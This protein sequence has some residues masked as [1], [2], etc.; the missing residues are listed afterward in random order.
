MELQQVI[1]RIEIEDLLCRYTHAIDTKNWDLLDEIFTPDAEIDYTEVGGI[2]AGLQEMKEW[3]AKSLS[4]FSLTQHLIGKSNIHLTGDKA[5]CSTI[6]HNPMVMP[7]NKEGKYDAEGK[8]T[9]TL[10]VGCWY[11]DTCVK[12]SDGW[13][14]S[15]KYEK[16]GF[17]HGSMPEGMPMPQ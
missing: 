6:V 13:R 2:K 11:E 15:K 16:Q 4:V 10:F 17:F 5:E 7:V 12:T 9:T 3:L 8:Q 1:D 14:I